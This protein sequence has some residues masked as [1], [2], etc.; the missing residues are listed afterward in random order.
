MTGHYLYK[1]VKLML[2]RSKPEAL[3]V[4]GLL[5]LVAYAHCCTQALPSPSMQRAGV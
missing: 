4:V 5:L 2:L 1:P 3:E